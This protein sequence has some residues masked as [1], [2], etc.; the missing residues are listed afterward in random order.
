MYFHIL[1]YNKC[2]LGVKLEESSSRLVQ[3]MFHSMGVVFQFHVL[4]F[5]VILGRLVPTESSGIRD[6][7]KACEESIHM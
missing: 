3:K 7:L 2:N 4:V 5:S 6:F 1:P